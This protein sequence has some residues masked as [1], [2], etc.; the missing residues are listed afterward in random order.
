MI[1]KYIEDESEY[2]LSKKFANLRISSGLAVSPKIYDQ[3]SCK[4]PDELVPDYTRAQ[5][6][7]LF[8]SQLSKTKVSSDDLGEIAHKRI[9]RPDSHYMVMEKIEGTSLDKL[10][11]EIIVML[12]DRIYEVYNL[13]CDKGY[14]LHDL[15]DRNI[16]LT[17]SG[18]IYFIDFDPNFVQHTKKSVELSKR[19]SKEKLLNRLSSR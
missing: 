9:S 8:K 16:M 12:I 6:D 11:V 14:I 7:I 13:F 19:F 15:L 18:R 3:I 2:A 1:I 4:I 10:P 5:R 17:K